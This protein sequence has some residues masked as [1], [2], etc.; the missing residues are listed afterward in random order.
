MQPTSDVILRLIKRTRA[1]L[2]D[3]KD[4]PL[5]E[6]ESFDSLLSDVEKLQNGEA[7]SVELQGRALGK[8]A[9]H[10]VNSHIEFAPM[11]RREAKNAVKEGMREYLSEA[12]D[13]G[14]V[15]R[16]QQVADNSHKVKIAYIAA[17]AVVLSALCFSGKADFVVSLV[18]RLFSTS[19]AQAEKSE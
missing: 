6:Q 12:K 1:K 11:I 2:F 14:G 19:P 17:A 10:T 15:L 3:S 16:V 4:I 13:S 7:C 5:A 8:L 18:S 9:V